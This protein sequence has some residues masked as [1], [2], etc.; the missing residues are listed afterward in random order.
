M[1]A[2]EAA[3]VTGTLPRLKRPAGW[4][5]TQKGTKRRAK[6]ETETETAPGP[7]P[8]LDFRIGSGP[9]LVWDLDP[10]LWVR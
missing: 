5:R 4:N 3:V 2:A 8:I 9:C 7:D 1:T 10:D 6:T